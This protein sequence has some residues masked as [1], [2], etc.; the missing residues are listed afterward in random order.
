MTPSGLKV[1]Y[2]A[3]SR[4]F[5]HPGDSRRFA[6]Y[7]K[8]R[9]FSIE[10]ANPN[11]RYDLVVVSQG[12]DLSIWGSYAASPVIY[13]FT[14]SYLAIP[15][16]DL[17]GI[18]RGAAK[19]IFGQ[20]SRLRLNHWRAIEDM[21]RRAKA[22][23]CVTEEQRQNIQSFSP[24]V[25]VILDM[26]HVYDRVKTDYSAGPIFNLVWEGFPENAGAF[27]LIRDALTR[28]DSSFPL[29]LHVVTKLKVARFMGR[30]LQHPTSDLLAGVMDRVFLYDWNEQIAPSIITACDLAVIPIDLN[31]PLTTG[32]PENKLYAF[33]RM[34]LPV[35]VSATPAYSRAMRDAGL[36]MA[37][38]SE[39][40]WAAVLMRLI[41]NADARRE[42]GLRGRAFAETQAS[43]QKLLGQWDAVVES[44]LG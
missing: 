24:N 32:K 42:C 38:R 23:V 31:N 4:D 8:A 39:D 9:G 27:Q 25:H 36:P 15:R 11:S 16:T 35:V 6:H 1:G 43:E 18:F 37:C 29:A 21:C 19:F 13:D 28:V 3:L 2:V 34:G 14:D 20:S 12:A 33:W 30:F 26:L 10:N 22:V 17:K 5:K 40:D 41:G 44:V 7:A